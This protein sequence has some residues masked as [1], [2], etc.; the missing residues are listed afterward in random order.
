MGSV[1]VDQDRIDEL[2][3][4]IRNLQFYDGAWVNS[5]GS[6]PFAGMSV[7]DPTPRAAQAT[8]SATAVRAIIQSASNGIYTVTLYG[9]GYSQASTGTAYLD[10]LEI[11][12]GE[13]LPAGTKV[14]AYIDS[15]SATGDG[16]S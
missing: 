8:A 1:W 14:L 9:K 12:Y 3:A 11:A 4:R 2:D 13:T 10:V 7:I 6:G 15:A 16:A 5:Y